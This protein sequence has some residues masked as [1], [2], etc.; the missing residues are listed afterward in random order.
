M[1]CE[2]SLLFSQTLATALCP[3]PD[4]FS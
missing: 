3:E 1:E 2:G 4:I